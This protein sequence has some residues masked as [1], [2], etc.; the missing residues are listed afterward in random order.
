MTCHQLI[1]PSYDSGENE[2]FRK[3]LSGLEFYEQETTKIGE[4]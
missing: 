3:N 2:N 1:T 4:S